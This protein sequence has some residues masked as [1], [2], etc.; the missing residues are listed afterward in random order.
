MAWTTTAA[1]TTP[2]AATAWWWEDTTAQ[3]GHQC[4]NGSEFNNTDHN[5][6]RMVKSG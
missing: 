4:H 3:R 5:Y 1:M 6:L 2:T